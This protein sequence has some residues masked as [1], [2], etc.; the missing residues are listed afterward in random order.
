VRPPTVVE[1]LDVVGDGESGPGSGAERL[2]VVH[3][4]FNAAN[5]L[6]AAALSQH[7]PVRPTLVRTW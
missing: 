1:D 7:T 4:V 5:K 2:P 3:L 6:S